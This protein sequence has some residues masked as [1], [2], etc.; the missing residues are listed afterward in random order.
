MKSKSDNKLVL[1]TLKQMQKKKEEKKPTSFLLCPHRSHR[2]HAQTELFLSSIPSPPPLSINIS[3]YCAFSSLSCNH[4]FSLKPFPVV[5]A[6][7]DLPLPRDVMVLI[8]CVLVHVVHT[9]S[10]FRIRKS[11]RE[12]R[13]NWEIYSCMC[14]SIILSSVHY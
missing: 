5:L 8:V 2:Q 3:K 11:L 1:R 10:Y 14:N 12:I 13:G 4:I 6:E 9:D 7:S